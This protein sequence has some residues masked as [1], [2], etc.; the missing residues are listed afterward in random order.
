MQIWCLGVLT[1]TQRSK[2]PG[3]PTLRSVQRLALLRPGPLPPR[4]SGTHF[5][6]V[7]GY[8]EREA[9]L[10]NSNQGRF[11]AELQDD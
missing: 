3:A 11:L 5:R 1:A 8:P 6:I 9:V 7:F 4:R 2:L 10:L